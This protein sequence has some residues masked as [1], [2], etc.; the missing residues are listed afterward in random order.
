MFLGNVYFSI[1]KEHNLTNNIVMR[2]VSNC[3][4]VYKWDSWGYLKCSVWMWISGKMFLKILL[5]QKYGE[6]VN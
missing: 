2:Q 5:L 1:R 6:I 3:V 4:D